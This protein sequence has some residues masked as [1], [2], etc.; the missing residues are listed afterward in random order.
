MHLRAPELS[1]VLLLL[2]PL[3]VVRLPLLGGALRRRPFAGQGID[4]RGG[5]R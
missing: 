4:R 1:V 2:L 5:R 3:V